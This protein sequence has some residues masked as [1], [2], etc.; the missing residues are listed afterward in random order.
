MIDIYLT[1]PTTGTR[2]RFDGDTIEDIY[3]RIDAWS[4]ANLLDADDRY[5]GD[6]AI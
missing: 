1:D 2:V 6:A 4:G 5:V 3:N